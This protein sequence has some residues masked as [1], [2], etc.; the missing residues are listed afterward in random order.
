MQMEKTI[1]I[2]ETPEALRRGS[3]NGLSR[4]FEVENPT[5]YNVQLVDEG[6]FPGQ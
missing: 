6:F 2:S 1:I 5:E 4:V 3:Q